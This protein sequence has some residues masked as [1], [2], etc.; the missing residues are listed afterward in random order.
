MDRAGLSLREK[1]REDGALDSGRVGIG[2]SLGVERERKTE[3]KRAN[4]QV[5]LPQQLTH[6]P[7]SSQSC[8]VL[9]TPA[10]LHLRTEIKQ[11]NGSGAT[12]KAARIE[13]PRE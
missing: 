2:R 5:Q 12:G 4:D 8:R 13:H 11:E 6:L 10:R 7:A 3:D 9:P 1:V